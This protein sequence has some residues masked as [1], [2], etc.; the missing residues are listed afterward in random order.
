LSDRADVEAWSKAYLPSAPRDRLAM[1]RAIAY[2]TVVP[3]IAVCSMDTRH[4]L[5]YWLFFVAVGVLCGW[6][7]RRL[8]PAALSSAPARAL[9]L[10]AWTLLASFLGIEVG[11][12]VWAAVG[13]P[14][15]WLD[16]SPD[17]VRYRLTLDME[18]LGTRPN[19]RGFND[20]E[21]AQ[22]KRPGV[23]RVAA[24]GDSYTVGMVPF[25]EGYVARV[26]EA[27]GPGV[28]V[29]NL[30]V[31]H[32]AVREYEEVLRSEGLHLHPDLVLLG[33]Y[34]GNDVRQDPPRGPF[35]PVGSKAVMAGRVLARLWT[36]GS[37]Y[38]IALQQDLLLETAPDGSR[39]ERPLQTVEHHLE[40]SWGRID[41]LLR[42]PE[43]G[44]MRR[45]WRDTEDALRDLVRLCR[46]RG[47]P[48][49]ATLAPDETQ[50]DD[51]LFRSLL[52][53]N[54]ARA[55]DF[56]RG[57]PNRRLRER[58]EALGVPV[59][60]FTPALRAAEAHAHTYH[61]RG[62]HWNA[63]GNAA[64]ADALAPWLADRIAELRRGIAP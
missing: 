3:W 7:L 54:G 50:V 58:L 41:R 14:P 21:R 49:V 48:I 9:D 44:R 10:V 45:A 46:E 26:D 30:G 29:I 25:G 17:S 61:L 27:L 33:V 18:W 20:V 23:I 60:D 62:V 16:V 2:V 51:E 11:L 39:V 22:E 5:R 42:A 32:T 34:V 59:L 55:E 12:R 40:R 43:R 37:L 28:E 52:A 6:L 24:L 35:S 1:S 31:V 8:A 47:L 19:S 13:D 57:Y 15:A 4:G 64:A 36:S 53:A 38:P 63:H 56:D